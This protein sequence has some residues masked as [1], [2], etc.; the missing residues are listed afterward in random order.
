MARAPIATAIGARVA[1]CDSMKGQHEVSDA[2]T[3]RAAGLAGAVLFGGAALMELVRMS[4]L[5][6]PWPGFTSRVDWIISALAIVLW[7][8]SAFVLGFRNHQ[9]RTVAILGV[10]ALF[11]YGILGTVGRSHFGIVY[12]ALAVAMIVLERL[13]FRGKLPIGRH[14]DEPIRQ[15]AGREIL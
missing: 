5:K 11:V 15:N 12:I 8:L 3:R 10:F 2:E 6:I 14:T 1:R 13:A 4:T 9:H 7:S